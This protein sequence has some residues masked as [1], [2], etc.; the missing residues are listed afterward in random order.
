MTVTALTTAEDVPAPASV[1]MTKALNQALR[2]SLRED[3][4]VLIFGEDVGRLGGV[5]RVTEGLRK[6]FG[7]DR[8]W[9]S[10]LAESGIVGTAIGMAMAGMRPVVEMQFDAYAYPAFEQIVSHVAKMRNRTKGQVSLPL[11][12]RI[13]YA[14]DIGGVEHHSDSSEAYW[15]STPGLT[16]ITPSNPADAYS[17]LR[18]SIASD[19]PVIFMEPKSRYWMK[20][21]LSLPVQTAPMDRAQVVR[22]GSD[23]TLLAY[24]PTVRT[25]L[26]AAEDGAEHGLSIEV[27]DLRSLSPFDDETVSASVRKTSRAAIIHEAAQF[28][29]YGAEVAARVTEANFTHLS[30][31]ILRITGFDVPY[32]SPKLEEYFLPTAERILDALESWDW[33][34]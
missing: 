27:I 4:N 31:P 17:L 16:V 8:V 19:D 30:A 29:G 18:E 9:D 3:E 24:G 15:C 7:P 1:T 11:T 22:V 5:F 12:I 28:G 20:D 21:E 10:P 14:G 23:V 26:A 33:E 32:P 34:L 2:D 13:P 6:E 25:A